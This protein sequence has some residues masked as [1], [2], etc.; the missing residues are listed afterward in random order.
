M[1]F[2]LG[3]II[4]AFSRLLVG[5]RDDDGSKDL[6]ILVLRYELRVLRRK[7]GPPKLRAI[8]RVLLA[9]A[10]RSLL[11]RTSRCGVGYPAG[12]QPDDGPR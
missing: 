10:S 5:S 1:L 4:R 9:E 3:L 8:D 6:E 7:T 12:S 11:D 2:L